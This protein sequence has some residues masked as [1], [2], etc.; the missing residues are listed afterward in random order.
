MRW[1]YGATNS[2]SRQAK[3]KQELDKIGCFG[4]T[5]FIRW[6]VMVGES[7]FWCQILLLYQISI[8][9][10]LKGLFKRVASFS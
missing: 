4:S 6:S 7:N 10:G 5:I 1:F 8:R 2:T 3:Y 9:L